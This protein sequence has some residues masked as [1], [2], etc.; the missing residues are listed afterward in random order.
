MSQNRSKF[1]D[2][3]RRQPR[4]NLQIWAVEL[5]ENSRY[6]HMLSNL[7]MSGFFIE[8]KLPFSVGSIIDF[9]ME[10]DGDVIS[11]KGKIV[12]NY[13]RADS[14]NTG[15]GVQFVDLNEK[16]KAKLKAYLKKLEM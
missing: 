11:F 16:E 14:H 4:L 1:Q 10:L 12:N 8:K 2:E 3:R 15:A 9:E 13:E 5:N 6:Y 7:S